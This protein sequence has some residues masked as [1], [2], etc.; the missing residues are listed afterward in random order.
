MEEKSRKK[1]IRIEQKPKRKYTETISRAIPTMIW[2]V[3]F[4][5]CLRKTLDSIQ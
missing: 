3:S 1:S 4:I 5:F 2:K